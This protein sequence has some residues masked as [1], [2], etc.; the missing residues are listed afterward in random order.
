MLNRFADLHADDPIDAPLEIQPQANA[1][2]GP[3]FA[4]LA[5]FLGNEVGHGDVGEDQDQGQ[6]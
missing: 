2:I 4:L 3:E 6:N 5:L 1:V